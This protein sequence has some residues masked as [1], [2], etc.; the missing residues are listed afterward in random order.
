MRVDVYCNSILDGSS[1]LPASTT[2][3]QIIIYNALELLCIDN[4]LLI[5]LVFDKSNSVMLV[6]SVNLQNRIKIDSF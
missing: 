1:I 3:L 4:M 2:R 6:R 5:D